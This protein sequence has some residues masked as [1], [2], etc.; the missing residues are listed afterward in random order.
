[1]P[2]PRCG[3]PRVP[4]PLSSCSPSVCCSPYADGTPA[5]LHATDPNK[6]ARGAQP[7]V[8][9]VVSSAPAV[10]PSPQAPAVGSQPPSIPAKPKAPA[11]GPQPPSIPAKP[12]EAAAS[13]RA[14]SATP[15]EAT[16]QKT[17]E[18]T[19]RKACEDQS[20]VPEKRA[21]DD[22]KTTVVIRAYDKPCGALDK[23]M[24]NL[25]E[26]AKVIVGGEE[27]RPWSFYY[28]GNQ[29]DKDLP[30]W[31]EAYA[32]HVFFTS[33]ECI[34]EVVRSGED[35]HGLA[36]CLGTYKVDDEDERT[37]NKLYEDAIFDR[38]SSRIKEATLEAIHEGT[39]EDQKTYVT[40][41]MKEIRDLPGQLRCV[42]KFTTMQTE[43]VKKT[44]ES[45]VSSLFESIDFASESDNESESE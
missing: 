35:Y 39:E 19:K 9:V 12:K 41:I 23:S 25:D 14:V 32:V 42:P 3:T 6:G 10:G 4:I 27:T 11:V 17:Q 8:S 33:P 31:M 44:V 36:S 18:L 43:C 15:K 29:M 28:L 34:A 38:S 45:M 21:K 22:G 2:E 16:S 5:V 7:L 40:K 20:P 13:A 24:K 30:K 1:M 37:A 26:I